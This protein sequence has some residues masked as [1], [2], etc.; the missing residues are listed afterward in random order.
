MLLPSIVMGA[1]ILAY[2]AGQAAFKFRT[3]LGVHESWEAVQATT[4]TLGVFVRTKIGI[5]NPYVY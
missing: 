5:L 2:G 4:S 3:T 1:F